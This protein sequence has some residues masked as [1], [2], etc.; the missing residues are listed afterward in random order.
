MTLELAFFLH[1]AIVS[2][3]SYFNLIEKAKEQI[4]KEK[5]CTYFFASQSADVL[6]KI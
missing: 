3:T 2:I 1:I 6:S 5:V 4:G